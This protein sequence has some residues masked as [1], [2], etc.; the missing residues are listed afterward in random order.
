MKLLFISALLGAFLAACSEERK[1]YQA[2]V[3]KTPAVTI[4]QQ[5]RPARDEAR[6][7]ENALGRHARAM[8]EVR[9]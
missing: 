3:P 4:F 2:P 1:P 8:E 9:A 6:G 7:V 5:E